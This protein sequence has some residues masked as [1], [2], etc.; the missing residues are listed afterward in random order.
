MSDVKITK[1]TPEELADLDVDSWS[2]WE[3]EPSS[4]DW[5]Y[6]AQE[7]F[8]VLEGRVKVDTPDGTV[9]FGEGD[10]VTFP[11]GMSCR[12]HVVRTIRKRFTFE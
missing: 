6:D 11:A 3:C 9:E 1:P 7:T 12:W 8:Y 10:L 4:F 2:P 5:T